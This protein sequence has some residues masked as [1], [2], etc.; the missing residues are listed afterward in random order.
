MPPLSFQ[1]PPPR[2]LAVRRHFKPNGP[3]ALSPHSGSRAVSQFAALVESATMHSFAAHSLR[4]SPDVNLAAI[5]VCLPITW[6]VPLM[7]WRPDGLSLW[8]HFDRGA[9]D[10][11]SCSRCANLHRKAGVLDPG[12]YSHPVRSWPGICWRWSSRATGSW[13][14]AVRL[15]VFRA[16]RFGG[17]DPHARAG[18]RWYRAATT[19]SA[20]FWVLRC[21]LFAL[22]YVFLAAITWRQPDTSRLIGSACWNAL[23][24][25]PTVSRDRMRV[26]IEAAPLGRLLVSRIVAGND[27]ARALTGIG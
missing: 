7:E 4:R 25:Q 1:A 15:A 8:E 21:A 12:R 5:T 10:F 11:D 13:R 9:R 22:E 19:G 26:G 23:F 2:R 3:T 18:G 20:I 14:P 6:P 17:Q 27:R 16:R 24:A